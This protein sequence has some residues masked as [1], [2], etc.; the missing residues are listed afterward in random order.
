MWPIRFVFLPLSFFLDFLV[1]PFVFFFCL[2]VQEETAPKPLQAE[3][4]CRLHLRLFTGKIVRLLLSTTTASEHDRIDTISI[5]ISTRAICRSRQSANFMHVPIHARL[6]TKNF[7]V[8]LQQRSKKKCKN[9]N[10]PIYPKVLPTSNRRL[11]GRSFGFGFYKSTRMLLIRRLLLFAVRRTRRIAA[12]SRY[13][14]I[15]LTVDEARIRVSMH[16]R[17]NL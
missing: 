1:L 11:R 12:Q 17:I 9:S 3:T 2:H 5:I 6:V 7:R 13:F 4:H 10:S 8:S 15:Q 14:S 16:Q